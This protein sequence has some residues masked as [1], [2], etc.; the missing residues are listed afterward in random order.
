MDIAT[1]TPTAKYN[2]RFVTISVQSGSKLIE[3][4]LDAHQAM[5]LQRAL[6]E[7]TK[8]AFC[9]QRADNVLH[10]TAKRYAD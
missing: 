2:G 8:E 1:Q 7:E 3:L 4:A 9:H 6:A 10:F 5:H